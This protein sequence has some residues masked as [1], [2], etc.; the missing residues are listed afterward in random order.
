[1]LS[2]FHF[3]HIKEKDQKG[4]K[5]MVACSARRMGLILSSKK[6]ITEFLLRMQAENIRK[7]DVEDLMVSTRHGNVEAIVIPIY[8]GLNLK[9][10]E[11]LR[12]K[13]GKLLPNDFDYYGH[14]CTF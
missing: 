2:L 9:T 7:E 3:F 13:Y 8:E 6:D 4:D 5:T 12:Q 14:I 10:I 1:M 11:A